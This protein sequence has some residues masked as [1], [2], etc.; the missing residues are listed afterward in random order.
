MNRTTTLNS[1]WMVVAAGC[2][3]VMG[4]CV[5]YAT[6][7]YSA[8]ELVFY[9]SLFGLVAIVLF[10]LPRHMSLATPHIRLHLSR[11]ING[12]IAMMLF[13]YTIPHLPLATALSLNYTSPIFLTIFL[14]LT[15]HEK[16]SLVLVTSILLGFVGVVLL[17]NPIL[18]WSFIASSGPGLVCG[19]LTGFVYLQVTQLGRLNE[20]EWRT[21]F[22]FTLVCSIAS[23]SWAM[24]QK[25]HP[26]A[27]ADIPLLV[28]IGFAATIGQLTMTR[29]YRKG[30]CLTVA[31]LAYCTVVF[32]SLLDILLW[33]KHLSTL[34]WLAIL[35]IICAGLLSILFT[36]NKAAANKAEPSLL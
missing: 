20:P 3:A 29:A 32:A 19:I 13:F 5:K 28:G 4:E 2:F 21:V 22:Y 15:M 36:A 10:T 18:H 30:D 6:V 24:T 23:A 17:L 9:R 8:A 31:S 14:A 11:S 12:F 16:V 26:I 35:L 34:N 7:K 25:F 33:H 27:M 1:L